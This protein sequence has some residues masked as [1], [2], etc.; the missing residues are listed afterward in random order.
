[1]EAIEAVISEP[2]IIAE[3]RQKEIESEIQKRASLLDALRASVD[4]KAF[5][6]VV[7]RMSN[8]TDEVCTLPVGTARLLFEEASG[9]DSADARSS[10]RRGLVGADGTCDIPRSR[11]ARRSSRGHVTLKSSHEFE[12]PPNLTSR[13]TH[14]DRKRSSSRGSLLP[15]RPLTDTFETTRR[16]RMSM[17]GFAFGKP[18]SIEG[19]NKARDES[20]SV[21]HRIMAFE[22]A[23][24]GA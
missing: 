2:E 5:A 17:P 22:S 7:R 15:P 8:D 6:A 13:T 10:N 4:M 16:A 3:L 12:E 19:N 14:H 9:E 1:M 11:P 21:R 20:P 18:A 23:K 24:G